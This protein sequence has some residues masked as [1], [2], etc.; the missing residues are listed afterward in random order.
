VVLRR[1]PG[2]FAGRVPA[3]ISDVNETGGLP[4]DPRQGPGMTEVRGIRTG[5]GNTSTVVTRSSF[6]RLDPDPLRQLSQGVRWHPVLGGEPPSD[7]R[8]PFRTQS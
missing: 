6:P 8:E 3:G 4:T 2:G 7:P 1:G 5:S